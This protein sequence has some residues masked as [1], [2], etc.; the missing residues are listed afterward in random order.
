MNR[1]TIQRNISSPKVATW[2]SGERERERKGG[3]RRDD[4]EKEK[5]KEERD[6]AA[7]LPMH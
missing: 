4:D 2:K 3:E 1:E 6:G 5:Y 7:G